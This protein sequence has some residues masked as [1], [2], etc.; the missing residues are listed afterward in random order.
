MDNFD[1]DIEKIECSE[2]EILEIG[3]KD[4]TKTDK[5]EGDVELAGQNLKLRLDKEQG[6]PLNLWGGLDLKISSPELA[7]ISD[8]FCPKFDSSNIGKSKRVWNRT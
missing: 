6:M 2:V 7:Q 8:K 4:D 1:P 5:I 3:Q